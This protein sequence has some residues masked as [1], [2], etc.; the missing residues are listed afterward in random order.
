MVKSNLI[1]GAPGLDGVDGKPG[2]TQG[3]PGPMGLPGD[4]GPPGGLPGPAGPQGPQGV[5]GKAGKVGPQGLPGDRT[6]FIKPLERVTTELTTRADD[7]RLLICDVSAPGQPNAYIKPSNLNLLPISTKTGELTRVPGGV[8]WVS[9]E[10]FKVTKE[11]N[12]QIYGNRIRNGR[13]F[14]AGGFRNGSGKRGYHGLAI[15]STRVYTIEQTDDVTGTIYI[16]VFDRNYQPQTGEDI[17]L[18]GPNVTPRDWGLIG[19]YSYDGT[20]YNELYVLTTA[21]NKARKY[22]IS[23]K[24]QAWEVNPR[25][26]SPT[27]SNFKWTGLTLNGPGMLMIGYGLDADNNWVGRLSNIGRNDGDWSYLREISANSEIS[28]DKLWRG[29]AVERGNTNTGPY[30]MISGNK[31]I[32]SKGYTNNL[33][34]FFNDRKRT[35]DLR[36]PLPSS[37]LIGNPSL[38]DYVVEGI[39]FYDDTLYLHFSEPALQGTHSQIWHMTFI[40]RIKQARIGGSLVNF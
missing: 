5:P 40:K 15:T 8:D 37:P 36:I 11:E 22:F 23:T 31:L 12:T 33:A 4:P 2:G 30:Y 39:N 21:S 35:I 24:Q 19:A 34:T 6:H 9:S 27:P 10:G 20:N 14:F 29:L 13:R 3:P 18:A 28:G 25:I 16:R 26:T 1:I 17:V 7:D 32:A 38:G